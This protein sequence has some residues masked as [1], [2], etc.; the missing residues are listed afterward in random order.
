MVDPQGRST[1][2]LDRQI[3]TLKN[4]YQRLMKSHATA[5][6]VEILEKEKHQ[7]A[8]QSQLE[9]VKSL[10]RRCN[11]L[12]KAL[13]GTERL[14]YDERLAQH[15]FKDSSNSSNRADLYDRTEMQRL[16]DEQSNDHRIETDVLYKRIGIL[17]KRAEAAKYQQDQTLYELRD[18]RSRFETGKHYF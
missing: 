3:T 10:E 14:L 7:V 18:S 1:V 4:E 2:M 12:E 8:L 16:L 13:E 15:K 17:M 9:F 11:H 5:L 6:N